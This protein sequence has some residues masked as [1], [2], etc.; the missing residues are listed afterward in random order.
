MI[1]EG[2]ELDTC[3]RCGGSGY[4]QVEHPGSAYF[5]DAVCPN[6]NDPPNEHW[7]AGLVLYP[8]GDPRPWELR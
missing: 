5:V 7:P 8:I 2:Y 1:P 4:V 3:H 6:C